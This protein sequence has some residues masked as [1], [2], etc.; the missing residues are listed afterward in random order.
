MSVQ[1][2]QYLVYGYML[3]FKEARA[4]LI[5]TLGEETYQ[6]VSEQY[7]DNAFTPE[8]VEVHGC[9][10]IEDGMGGDY[11]FFGKIYAKSEN[12]EVLETTTF[13]EVSERDRIIT[14]HEFERLFGKDRGYEP[15]TY[16][17]THYR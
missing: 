13:P 12:Y 10:M 9:S 4:I 8:I 3:D 6:E 2:N 1:R 15:T 16:L 5:A 14:E 11:T 17:I 7:S